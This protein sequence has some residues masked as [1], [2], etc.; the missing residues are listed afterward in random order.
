MSF[1]LLS[2]QNDLGSENFQRL[3]RA[4]QKRSKRLYI[5]RQEHAANFNRENA[6]EPDAD[7]EQQYRSIY[8]NITDTEQQI[9]SPSK[10]ILSIRL[11]EPDFDKKQLKR[12]IDLTETEDEL[13]ILSS[14]K[15]SQST[16]LTAALNP[17]ITVSTD[18]QSTTKGPA[19]I[20]VA[21]NKRTSEEI[22]VPTHSFYE[23]YVYLHRLWLFI[24]YFKTTYFITRFHF[25][26]KLYSLINI[27]I[28]NREPMVEDSTNRVEDNV[29]EAK[30]LSDIQEDTAAGFAYKYRSY[31]I[32]LFIVIIDSPNNSY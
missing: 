19:S 12:S 23:Q 4:F 17:A 10:K 6:N 3:Q 18:F 32:V 24:F 21:A 25:I 15:T 13:Q 8:S 5:R 31:S 14:S 20:C 27:T 29:E 1:Y 26:A 7:P 30:F 28:L 22:I 2:Y 11:N 9:Q 16:S